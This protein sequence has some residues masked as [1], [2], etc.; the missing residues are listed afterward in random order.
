MAST[1][2]EV[3]FLFGTSQNWHNGQDD[4]VVEL[5]NRLIMTP[6]AAKRLLIILHQTVEQ[7]EKQFGKIG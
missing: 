5:S 7:Y 2:E 1:R 6:S 4:V 3:M